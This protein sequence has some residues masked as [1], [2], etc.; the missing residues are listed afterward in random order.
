MKKI[1]AFTIIFSLFA[2]LAFADSKNESLLNKLSG[3]KTFTAEFKQ[4]N[5][6][7]DFGDDI[8]TGKVSIIMGETALWD[9]NEPYNSWYLITDKNVDYFDEINNQLVKMNAKEIKEYA[10]LQV[11]MD[12]KKISSTFMVS[13]KKDMLILKPKDSNTGLLYINILFKDNVISQLE[14]KDNTGNTTTITFSQTAYDKEI[15]KN[16]F[17]KKLPKDVTVINNGN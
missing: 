4:V 10:L 9:Y 14:S 2:F 17:K 8:Y 16:T 6:L 12:F 13:E 11:L 5:N 7:K 1:T 3:V 15:S